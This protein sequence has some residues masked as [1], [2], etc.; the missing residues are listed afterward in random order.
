[1]RRQNEQ[2]RKDEIDQN[3]DPDIHRNILRELPRSGVRNI[4]RP[5]LSD[6]REPYEDKA[7]RNGQ[8][9]VRHFI[10]EALRVRYCFGFRLFATLWR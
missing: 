2:H 1:M 5:W 3:A 6:E 7:S 10:T 9:E 4:D 8:P